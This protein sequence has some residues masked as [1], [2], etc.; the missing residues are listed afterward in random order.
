[1][2][3]DPIALPDPMTL[4]DAYRL[5]QPYTLVTPLVPVASLSRALG[6]DVFVK[7][8]S[9]QITGAFKFRGAI[10]RLLKFTDSERKQGVT[11]YSSGNFARGLAQAGKILNIRV[12]LVIPADA[13][14]IKIQSAKQLGAD[15]I[16]CHDNE[17]SKE[18]A[19]Q[20][21]AQHIAKQNDSLLLHPFDDIEMIKG[22]AAVAVELMQQ[23]K[24]LKQ[25]CQHLLCPVGGGSLVA[26]C[27]L[28][29]DPLHTHTQVYAI[30]P[31]GY[32]GMNQ[33]LMVGHRTRASGKNLSHCDALLSKWPGVA[34]FDVARQ[35]RI[36]GLQVSEHFV[37]M[38]MQ[39]A[40][41][42]LKLVLE[43]SGAIAIGALLQYPDRFRQQSVVA[44]ASGG[45][46]DPEL[47]SEIILKK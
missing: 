5:Q 35:T 14:A 12:T 13:P 28:M 29:M 30:E 8:E 11:A 10:Y 2:P 23:L 40:F 19:A 37:F 31:E 6:G 41:E 1:M 33:S 16:L 3:S 39:L 4:K 44:I 17:P 25:S 43:P 45:N 27:S 46:V 47:F 24:T 9:L 18:E 21:L 36:R 42:E 7:A 20:N 32:A 38:A 34:N 15:V 26:G 22:Q